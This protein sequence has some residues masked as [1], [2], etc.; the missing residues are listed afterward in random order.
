M[1]KSIAI[2][3]VCLQGK[4]HSFRNLQTKLVSPLTAS[5]VDSCNDAVSFLECRQFPPQK[6]R[7]SINALT[8]CILNNFYHEILQILP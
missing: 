4:L 3:S 8:N 1:P 7:L 6:S 5:L 2:L